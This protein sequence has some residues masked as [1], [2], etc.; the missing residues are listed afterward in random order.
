[1]KEILKTL[2]EKP[3][4]Y[5]KKPIVIEAFQLTKELAISGLI[6][7]K[8]LPFGIRL[9]GDYHTGRAW[10]SIQT[11]EGAMRANL[12]DWIIKG[13]KGEFYP[14]KPDIFEATY[15]PAEPPTAQPSEVERLKALRWIPCEERMPTRED[16]NESGQVLWAQLRPLPFIYT[17][18]HDCGASFDQ[19]SHWL[20][21]PPLTPTQPQEEGQS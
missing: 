18:A 1:M 3:A 4:Q 5:R 21:I 10:A 6:D 12:G 15:E 19:A 20:P 9:S 11:L 16:A 2:A 7:G 13:V 14:C 8:P 17:A